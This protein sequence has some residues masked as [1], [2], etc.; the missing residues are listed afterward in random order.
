MKY[1]SYSFHYNKNDTSDNNNNNVIF[2]R[3]AQHVARGSQ[4]C[5]PHQ[6]HFLEKLAIKSCNQDIYIHKI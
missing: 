2:I 4:D 3:G 6:L 1:K 5:G